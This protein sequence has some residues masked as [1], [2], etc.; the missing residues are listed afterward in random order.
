MAGKAQECLLLCVRKREG[1]QSPKDDGV[2][3]DDD[4]R[5]QRN[6]LVGNSLGKI[7][8]KKNRIRLAT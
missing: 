7:D 8:G 4:G 1:L 3:C 2:V 5:I 6:G